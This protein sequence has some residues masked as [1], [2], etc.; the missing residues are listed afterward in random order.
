MRKQILG[1]LIGLVM[2]LFHFVIIYYVIH[3]YRNDKFLPA[4]M[5]TTLGMIIP[6]FA[7]YIGTIIKSLIANQTNREKG[8]K[9]RLSYVILSS[10][11]PILYCVF[12]LS[13]IV[14]QTSENR[15]QSFDDFV[16]QLTIAES[17]FAGFTGYIISDLFG[18]A[19]NNNSGSTTINLDN[20]KE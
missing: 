16:L 8:N 19:Q 6:M 15:N 7:I 4:E 5:Q 17:A 13:I 2:I 18:N 9:V 14:D 12:V 20:E 10:I 3:C 11:V 1:E